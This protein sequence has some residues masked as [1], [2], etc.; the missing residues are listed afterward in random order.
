MAISV[1]AEILVLI[2]KSYYQVNNLLKVDSKRD[3]NWHRLVQN[4][5]KH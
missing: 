4:W 5:P 3:I 1:Y 2:I